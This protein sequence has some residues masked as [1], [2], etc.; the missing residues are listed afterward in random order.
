[1]TV[2]I[3]VT[4]IQRLKQSKTETYSTPVDMYVE[5]ENLEIRQEGAVAVVFDKKTKTIY[6]TDLA[7]ATAVTTL[8]AA[9]TAGLQWVLT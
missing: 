9:A 5:G 2:K 8:D 3:T 4:K 7:Y 1:M 6:T